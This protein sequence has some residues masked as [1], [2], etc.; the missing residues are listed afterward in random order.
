MITQKKYLH[1]QLLCDDNY[2]NIIDKI[3]SGPAW[4]EWNL[5]LGVYSM[6]ATS[7]LRI[8]SNHSLELRIS[9]QN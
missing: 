2:P 3:Y 9:R 5:S 7:I 6:V 4:R 1:S 8:C